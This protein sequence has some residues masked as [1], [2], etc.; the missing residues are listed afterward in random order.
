M[1]ATGMAT[2]GGWLTFYTAI[3]LSACYSQNL[4]LHDVMDSTCYFYCTIVYLRNYDRY[5]DVKNNYVIKSPSM[6]MHN[7]SAPP[8]FNFNAISRNY[9]V[10]C[11]QVCSLGVVLDGSIFLAGKDQY[12]SWCQIKPTWQIVMYQ[13]I[14]EIYGQSGSQH[15]CYQGFIVN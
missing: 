9:I 3:G 11:G 15:R 14:Q 7:T 1:Q 6:Y 8:V 12:R 10:L 4:I 13:R 5:R 2:V